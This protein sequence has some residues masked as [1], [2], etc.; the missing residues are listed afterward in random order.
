MAK[1]IRLMKG[2]AEWGLAGEQEEKREKENWHFFFQFCF[3]VKAKHKI[4]LRV[5]QNAKFLP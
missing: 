2:T 5:Y 3:V 4:Q 1:K